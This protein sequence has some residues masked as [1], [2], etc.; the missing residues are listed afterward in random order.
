MHCRDQYDPELKGRN[1]VPGN[2]P[3]VSSLRM[4]M[5]GVCVLIFC[6][7]ILCVGSGV[8]CDNAWM[9]HKTAVYRKIQASTRSVS[10]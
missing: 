3:K 2:V 4:I 1:R 7:Y 6:V 10:E 5:I 8:Q 9:S